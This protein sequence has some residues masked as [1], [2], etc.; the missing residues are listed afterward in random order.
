LYAHATSGYRGTLGRRKGVGAQ[1]ANEK[2]RLALCPCRLMLALHDDH[3]LPKC[4]R[5]WAA[6]HF[7]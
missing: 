4:S 2:R 6:K 3:F 1:I 7:D 5:Y